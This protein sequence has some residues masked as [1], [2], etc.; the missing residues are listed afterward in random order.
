MPETPEPEAFNFIKK[1]T[2]AQMFS[3]EFC[4]ISMNTFS[5]RATPVAASESS[6]VESL[7]LTFD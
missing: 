5:Y 7:L 1:E 3:C 2:L 4:E 6:V